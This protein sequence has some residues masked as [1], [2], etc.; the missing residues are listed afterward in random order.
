M[1]SWRNRFFEGNR[2]L[3]LPMW[4][5]ILR[6]GNMYDD[7][8][9][10]EYA[11]EEELGE[12]SISNDKQVLTIN[13]TPVTIRDGYARWYNDPGDRNLKSPTEE[14][15]ASRLEEIGI[16]VT[17]PA[18]IKRFPGARY[19]T[20]WYYL[21]VQSDMEETGGAM[22]SDEY[23]DEFADDMEDEELEEGSCG[24]MYSDDMEDEYADEEELEERE[25][26]DEDPSTDKDHLADINH[27][28]K[29]QPWEKA[30]HKKIQKNMKSKESVTHDSYVDGEGRDTYQ[31]KG[32]KGGTK[33]DPKAPKK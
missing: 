25:L 26:D 31:K 12:D 6:E 29:L 28:N 22:Y 23:E 24:A 21:P 20:F 18:E 13:R 32:K 11:D 15:V 16:K 9:E 33:A 17:G 27:D 19:G 14:E 30:R 8:M 3:G 10:D 4:E 5:S 1:T 2:G 7:E